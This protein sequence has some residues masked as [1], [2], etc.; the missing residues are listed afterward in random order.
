MLPPP[1]SFKKNE[2]FQA[3]ALGSIF[4]EEALLTPGPRGHI[5]PFGK[6]ETVVHFCVLKELLLC[7]S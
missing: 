3:D 5:V 7:K 6:Q 4:Q 1:R 2:P